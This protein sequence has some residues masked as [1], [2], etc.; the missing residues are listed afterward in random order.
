MEVNVIEGV[1]DEVPVL[2]KLDELLAVLDDD[3]V[4]DDVIVGDGE[5]VDVGV[6]VLD[7]VLLEE[8]DG[9]AVDDLVTVLVGERD[10]DKVDVLDGDFEEEGVWDEL[11]VTVG[12]T[13][14]DLVGDGDS[15]KV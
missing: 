3:A 9:V 8:E 7:G 11:G 1:I 5:W 6:S 15:V 10:L 12:V 2:V 4:T 13:V 14:A